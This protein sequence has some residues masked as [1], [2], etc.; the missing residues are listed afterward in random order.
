LLS[1]IFEN[2]SAILLHGFFVVGL[3]EYLRQVS[4][5]FAIMITKTI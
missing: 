4:S 5:I 2:I 1:V 3:I